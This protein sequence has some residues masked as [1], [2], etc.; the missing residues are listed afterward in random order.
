MISTSHSLDTDSKI[1]NRTDRAFSLFSIVQFPNADCTSS[2]STTTYGTCYTATECSDAGG[3]AD[4]N[5]AAGFGVCCIITT[6][7][8]GSTISTNT[9][10]I[11]NPNYPS[12]YTPSSTGTCTFTINK[13][14]ADVCQVRLDFQTLSGFDETGGVCSDKLAIEGQTGS[15]PPT[16]CGTTTGQHM[17]A[18]IGATSSDTATVTLTYGSTS[19]AKTWN[20][21]VRQISC[22]ATWKA[23]T[24]CTQYYTGVS[25]TIQSY[26]FPGGQLLQSMYYDN[27][28]RTEAG[29][30][31]IQYKETTGT[32]PDSFDF[33][34]NIA[35][36]AETTQGTC[37]VSY[38]YIPGLSPDGIQPLPATSPESFIDQSCGQVF[39]IDGTA[40]SLA[41]VSAKQPFVVG[42]YTD[43]TT[44]LTSPTT[45]FSLDY[46]QLPC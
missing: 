38:V 15:D 29:Y 13:C 17:Y 22:D 33:F 12:S 1:N 26:G 43:T 16:V 6:S 23:P 3:S 5:C 34:P 7:T 21:L 19:A 36:N 39:G 11:R 31:S 10:Y 24:D 41:L 45:G 27:C 42:V 2:S 9:S 44:T 37:S 8:C 40:V 4:G 46:T 25:G 30:C 32:T 35:A 20:V 14:S 18:E 28:I